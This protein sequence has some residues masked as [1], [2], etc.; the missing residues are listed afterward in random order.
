MRIFSQSQWLE[1]RNLL[2]WPTL[3]HE[4]ESS[5]TQVIW[6]DSGGGAASH[7]NSRVF[8]PEAG[9]W[10]LSR[11]ILWLKAENWASRRTTHSFKE[12][13]LCFEVVILQALHA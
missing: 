4:V 3:E 13:V 7:E 11:S 9:E 1:E 8:F 2:G 6:S 10:M 12:A 5:F